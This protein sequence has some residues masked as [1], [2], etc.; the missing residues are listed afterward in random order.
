MRFELTNSA[1]INS[2]S[3][4][5]SVGFCSTNAFAKELLQGKV[6]IPT[7]IDKATTKLIKEM[8]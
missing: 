3:L 8:Q 7:D 2:S 6:A 5:Q 4:R 1:P